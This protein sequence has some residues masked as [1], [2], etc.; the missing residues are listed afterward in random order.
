MTDAH[1]AYVANPDLVNPPDEF[2]TDSREACEQFESGDLPAVL[3][4]LAEAMD[5]FADRLEE[6]DRLDP[7]PAD[8]G[9]N[10][11][12]AFEG[13]L[14]IMQAPA[15]RL[16]PLESIADLTDQKVPD[17]QICQIYGFIDAYQ[18]PRMDLL[19]KERRQPGSV[20]ASPDGMDGKPWRDPREKD[21]EAEFGTTLADLLRA[22]TAYSPPVAAES[23]PCPETIEQLYAQGVP[24]QQAARMLKMDIH[25]VAE[26]Y[27]A[28]MLADDEAKKGKAKR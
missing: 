20:I 18:R 22:P 26:R 14:A 15:R 8:P 1:A 10:F 27:E 13:V 21:L 3:R 6:Y 23:P 7:Q 9:N 11:W 19:A 12:V 25:A 24:E 2:F 4:P 5:R 28:L 16:A 17:G